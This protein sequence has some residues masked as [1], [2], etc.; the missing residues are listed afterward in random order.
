MVLMRNTLH[1][2]DELHCCRGVNVV[3]SKH[4]VAV[5]SDLQCPDAG[6]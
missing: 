2:D 1:D 6:P 3:K 5:P 4:K